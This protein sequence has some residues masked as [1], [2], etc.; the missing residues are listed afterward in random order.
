MDNLPLVL[1]YPDKNRMPLSF[2]LDGHFALEILIINENMLA[3]V[4]CEQIEDEILERDSVCDEDQQIKN[5]NDYDLIYTVNKEPFQFDV[6]IDFSTVVNPPGCVY[7]GRSVRIDSVQIE[8]SWMG[9]EMKIK[10]N[11]KLLVSTLEIMVH[12]AR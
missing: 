2:A 7:P 8:A 12:I 5:P 6:D 3:D 4:L 10:W 1:V 9:R 11:K